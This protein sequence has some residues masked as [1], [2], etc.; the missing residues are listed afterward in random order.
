MK[1]NKKINLDNFVSLLWKLDNQYY[2]K[3]TYQT[4]EDRNFKYLFDMKNR[5]NVVTTL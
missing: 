1:T 5:R 4:F 2:H 3:F